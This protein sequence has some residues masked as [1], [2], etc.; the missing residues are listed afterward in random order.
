MLAASLTSKGAAVVI[1]AMLE[2]NLTSVRVFIVSLVERLST[3]DLGSK[4]AQRFKVKISNREAFQ[5]EVD[6]LYRYQG[7]AKHRSE[8]SRADCTSFAIVKRIRNA[9]H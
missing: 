8:I 9:S 1:T 2:I 6:G 7:L 3:C 4:T 5:D